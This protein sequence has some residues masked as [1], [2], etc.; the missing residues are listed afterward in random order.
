MLCLG[1]W[2]LSLT[3]DS[4]LTKNERMPGQLPVAGF[5]PVRPASKPTKANSQAK[6]YFQVGSSSNSSTEYALN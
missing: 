3:R 1:E 4:S 2:Q 5:I 6:K